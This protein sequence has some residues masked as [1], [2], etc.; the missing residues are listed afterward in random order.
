MAKALLRLDDVEV[1]RSMQVVLRNHRLTV[2]EGDCVALVGINGSGKS[3]LLETAAGLL[4]LERGVV[5]HGE[6]ERIDAEGRRRPS[7]L[8]VG[9]TLQKNGAIGSEVLDEHLQLAMS[10]SGRAID[11]DP[12][13]DA[14]RL[15]HRARDLIAHLSQGQARK[16][17]VLAGILPAFAA[18]SPGLVL[19]DE[20]A[21]GLD[22]HAVDRL[23]EW[24]GELRA[25]GHAVVMC[26]HDPRLRAQANVVHDVVELTTTPQDVD[27]PATAKTL[28][29]QSAR[30]PSP[31]RFG[32]RTHWRT[33]LW[34]N[35]NAM[36]ALLTLGVLLAL[37][38]LTRST[39][40]LQELG[41]VLAPALAAGLCGEP[42][43]NAMREERASSWWRAVGGG[44]PHASWL[45]L[46][47]GGI[48]TTM[49]TI[50]L[51]STLLPVHLVAGALLTW[52]AWHAVRWAQLSTDRLARPQAVMVGLL[53]PTL[54]LPYA[55]LLDLLTR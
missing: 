6:T 20:P 51:Q 9:L 52:T 11:L 36:A 40:P 1:R 13:L 3:T 33:L 47:L 30:P 23:C 26:T 14:F 42:L 4:P 48:V 27:L 38:D 25:A 50:S 2:N 35:T 28:V 12:F 10:Q 29:G 53:T 22:D 55:L 5:F 54:I 16:V 46:L 31:G 21:A 39:T 32:M 7:P 8:T 34:L 24:L 49:A 17:A 37:G 41:F 45:P 43:V 44:V 19:L 15:K 18:T